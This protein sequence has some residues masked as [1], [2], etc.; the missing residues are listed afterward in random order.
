M[1]D[2]TRDD[3][4]RGDSADRRFG[5]PA[6]DRDA[7]DDGPDA[8]GGFDG[9]RA[10][11]EWIDDV[12]DELR[13]SEKSS[14][15]T[16]SVIAIAA[17]SAGLFAGLGAMQWTWDF[18]L[19]LL[20]VL[21]VHELG[22]LIAMLMFGHRDVRMF[23]VPFM[24]AAVTGRS[25]DTAGWKRV[26]VSLAGPVPGVLLGAVAGVLGLIAQQE[27]VAIGGVIA[28]AINGFNL[29]PVLPLD[30]GWVLQ[31]TIFCRNQVLESIFRCVAIP[32]LIV[33]G[34]VLGGWALFV[35]AAFLAIAIPLQLRT[36]RLIAKLRDEGYRPE[37][38]REGRVTDADVTR[39]AREM[40][41]AF[42]PRVMTRLNAKAI[43]GLVDRV[44]ES[45]S[46][47]PPGWGLTFLFLFVHGATLIGAVLLA[48]V[49]FTM[50][51]AAVGGGIL[52]LLRQAA[53]APTIAI[54]CDA[55]REHGEPAVP[56]AA[57]TEGEESDEVAAE[58]EPSDEEA[59]GVVLF[60]VDCD[61]EAAAD[62]LFD[63]AVA[64]VGDAGRVV[65]VGQTLFATSDGG[66]EETVGR[67]FNLLA[68]V[69]PDVRARTFDD[70]PSA[71]L[72]FTPPNSADGDRL[73]AELQGY[74]GGTPVERL[75]P[76]WSEELTAS[77]RTARR[78]AAWL[79]ERLYA[80]FDYEPPPEAEE[81]NEKANEAQRR[82]RLKQ[83]EELYEQVG[84]FYEE[85]AAAHRATVR[86]EALAR[87]DGEVDRELVGLFFERIEAQTRLT[88]AYKEIDPDAGETDDDPVAAVTEEIAAITEKIEERQGRLPEGVIDSAGLRWGGTIER[89]LDG[90]IQMTWLIYA[91]VTVGLPATLDWI[92]GL[93][94]D[95]VMYGVATEN[96]ADLFD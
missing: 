52:D 56:P 18:V 14:I 34:V 70:P 12:I 43:A 23:F 94:V 54:G 75:I 15:N 40:D 1:A 73:L 30:G 47:R 80:D 29:L 45:L 25:R 11:E 46:I 21:A 89:R 20:V 19:I 5:E 58:E 71:S 3:D 91:D 76:P 65:R 39:I 83:A 31:N 50:Q 41:A 8:A 32:L 28:V 26:V 57:G 16:G 2:P 66:D 78:T 61:D 84:A 42:P 92:C 27:T 9:D 10:D 62:A 4:R 13:A 74:S 77:M 72:L 38:D 60:A 37:P 33:G 69:E 90:Q 95:D 63:E 81:L 85:A 86:E 35:V 67:L 53:D 24:G 49:L 17:I 7:Y 96:R 82:G 48:T 6:F 51:Q 79:Q 93:G 22:H 59:R 64:A 87:P 44:Y 68:A 36:D 55:V 88:E